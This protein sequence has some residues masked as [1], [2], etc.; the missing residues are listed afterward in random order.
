MMLIFLL[1]GV[2]QQKRL[3]Q[4]EL[5]QRE[6]ECGGRGDGRDGVINCVVLGMAGEEDEDEK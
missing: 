1:C 3:V 2:A 5:V 6:R 4:G